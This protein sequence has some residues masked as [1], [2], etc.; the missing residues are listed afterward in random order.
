MGSKS[1]IDQ[2]PK[3]NERAG[4]WQLTAGNQLR[5]VCPT[6]HTVDWQAMGDKEE[7]C[8]SWFPRALSFPPAKP[9]LLQGHISM[10]MRSALTAAEVPLV[11][12]FIVSSVIHILPLS[13]PNKSRGTLIFDFD[14]WTQIG[15]FCSRP[16]PV[17]ITERNTFPYESK[18]LW[19]STDLYPTKR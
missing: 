5:E 7:K 19:K 9:I 17:M 3:G 18:C 10:E 15:Q 8:R 14:F 1:V 6:L 11:F 12:S 2:N 13:C 4:H 16:F